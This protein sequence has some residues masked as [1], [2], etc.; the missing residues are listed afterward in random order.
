MI[1]HVLLISVMFMATLHNYAQK[2]PMKLHGFAQG[3]NVV[4]DKYFET[5][6]NK[7][8]EVSKNTDGA[9]DATVMPLVNA[10]GFGPKRKTRV[11]STVIDSLLKF[12]GYK[13]IELKDNKVIKKDVR[14]QLDFNAIAQGYS[15]DLISEFL[16]SKGISKYL[17]E[18][19]GEVYAKHKKLNGDYWKVGI[20]K[21][22]ENIATTNPLKAIVRLKN[23]ALSTSGNYRKFYVENGIKYSHEINPKTGYP[24]HN[25]LLS[26]SVFA[27]NCITADAYATAFMVM[28]L[29]KTI[30]FLTKNPN[31]EVYLIYSNTDGNYLIYESEGLKKILAE[32]Q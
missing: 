24:A 21:P 14:V 15:T 9:F 29:E 17:V 16:A 22:E 31:I 23:K 5:C 6:F 10:W 7:S 8:V 12:I 2:I 28:G 27:K 4:T 30:K 25:T 1:K 18:I 19:G 32:A 20:E 26:A 11:D 13:L 3:T